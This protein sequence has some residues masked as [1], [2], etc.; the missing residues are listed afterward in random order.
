MWRTS[1][2]LALLFLQ[3]HQWRFY[4]AAL[5]FQRL[6]CQNKFKECPAGSDWHLSSPVASPGPRP[7]G[8]QEL[9]AFPW[10]VYPQP[11]VAFRRDLLGSQKLVAVE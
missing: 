7:S 4:E 6:F 10:F 8:P 2:V 3:S 5:S 1:C 9:T 11:P